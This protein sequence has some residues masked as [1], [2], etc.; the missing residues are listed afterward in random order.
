MGRHICQTPACQSCVR[1][2]SKEIR[3][4]PTRLRLGAAV[5]VAKRREARWLQEAC[6]M[7]VYLVPADKMPLRVAGFPALHPD[8]WSLMITTTALLRSPS[9]YATYSTE[10][11]SSSPVTRK[12]VPDLSEWDRRVRLTSFNHGKLFACGRH[13]CRA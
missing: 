13:G 9:R 11:L 8:E 7:F 10:E 4:E 2:R 5:H 3:T 6:C 1:Q 12:E